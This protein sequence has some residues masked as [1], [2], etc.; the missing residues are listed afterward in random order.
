MRFFRILL[1]IIAITFF[2]ACTSE[3]S[4][5]DPRLVLKLIDSA[6]DYEEVNIHVVGAEVNVDGEWQ[7]LS[8]EENVYDLCKLVNGTS[9]VIA[10][11]DIPTGEIQEL[12]LILGEDNTL[13]LKDVTEPVKLST[14]SGQTSGYKI[15]IQE[16]LTTGITYTLIVDFDAA[17]SVVKAGNS[18]KYNLKPVVRAFPEAQDGAIS[19]T[20]DPLAS[21]PAIYAIIAED[22]ITSTFPDEDG[23]FML[24]GLD[25]P[26]YT[27]GFEP[28][29]GFDE[30]VLDEVPVTIGEIND[31]G[32]IEIEEEQ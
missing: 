12:R 15:K 3:D 30:K 16:T 9:E 13:K 20:I 21:N 14:P 8:V 11:E 1:P 17:R 26:S 32:T 27:V 24:R 19:G 28:A 10:D 2:Q 7:S 4:D 31:L 29:E 23:F 6:G 18:G 5:A 25:Q 22:T